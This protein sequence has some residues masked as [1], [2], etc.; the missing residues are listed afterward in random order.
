VFVEK[1]D[2]EYV[3]VRNAKGKKLFKTDRD[4]ENW[5]KSENIDWD[6][7]TGVRV[8]AKSDSQVSLVMTESTR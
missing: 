3:R 6:T 4:A 1:I 2:T 8:Q 5:I 7:M